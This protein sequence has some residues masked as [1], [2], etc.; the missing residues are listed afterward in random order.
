MG[1]LAEKH[2]TGAIV[3]PTF[4]AII[5]DQFQALR[6]GDRFFW[7]NQGFDPQTAAMIGKTTL[8]NFIQRNTATP[9]LQANV[10]IES[11]LPTHVRPH[12]TQPP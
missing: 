10:V 7:Q 9:R 5:A 2:A 6:A 3:G 8:T 1:G 11:A 12:A 4:Q